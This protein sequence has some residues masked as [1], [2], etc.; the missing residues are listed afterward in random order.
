MVKILGGFLTF[1]KICTNAE[2]KLTVQSWRPHMLYQ[3]SEELQQH[4]PIA[5]AEF[6]CF[7]WH[8]PR[9]LLQAPIGGKGKSNA[10]PVRENSDYN[11]E[12]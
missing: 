1:L 3:Q 8:Q 12:E 5:A 11:S 6:S 4:W 2:I 7:L 9:M 10:E